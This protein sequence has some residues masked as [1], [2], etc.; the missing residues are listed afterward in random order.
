MLRTAALMLVA[1]VIAPTGG[2]AYSSHAVSIR[3]AMTY[4]GKPG[5]LMSGSLI[6]H[7]PDRRSTLSID[8]SEN[9]DE[10]QGTFKA[11]TRFRVSGA[12][13]TI[14]FQ[15]DDA[16]DGDIL[17]SPNSRHLALAL[18]NG[19]SRSYALFIIDARGRRDISPIFRKRLNPPKRCDLRD[20][21][22]VGA[23]KWLS[24]TRLLVAAHQ[25]HLD[26]CPEKGRAVYY[27][28]DLTREAITETLT[29]AET[30]RRF[31]GTPGWLLG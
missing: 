26:S 13:G 6:S 9:G 25:S 28:Y 21:S 20:F 23:V 2:G 17:W 18:G 11:V 29:P 30:Q 14:G 8:Y 19:S 22:G 10:R 24:N 12:A 1:L 5:A 15:Y 31:P 4:H 7:S 27:I 3:D 16:L